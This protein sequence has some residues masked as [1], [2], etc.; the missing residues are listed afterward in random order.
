MFGVSPRRSGIRIAKLKPSSPGG[1]LKGKES[2]S[3]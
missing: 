1:S 2:Q 3:W